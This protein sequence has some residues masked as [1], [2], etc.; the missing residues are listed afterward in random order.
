M[1]YYMFRFFK[2]SPIML[3]RWN[4]H[5]N[6]VYLNCFQKI[7]RC[8]S[9]NYEDYSMNPKKNIKKD[10]ESSKNEKNNIPID[11]DIGVIALT[12]Y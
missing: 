8:H 6:G 12:F 4:T 7:E 11:E 5:N 10:D 2:N 3:H 1:K 9:I